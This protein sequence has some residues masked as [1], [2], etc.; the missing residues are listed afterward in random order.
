VVVGLAVALGVGGVAVVDASDHR[1]DNQTDH[2]HPDEVND[3]GDL[4]AVRNW[5]EDRMAQIHLDCAENLSAGERAACRR[6]DDEYP[7]YLD[8]YAS[9]ERDSPGGEDTA[10]TFEKAREDQ[11]EFANETRAHRETY[12]EYQEARAAGDEERSRRL[13][14]ELSDRAQRIEELGGSLN[15]RFTRLEGRTGRDYGD[16][17][18]ATNETTREVRRTTFEIQEVEFTPSRLSAAIENTPASFR[19]PS[20]VEGRLTAENGTALAG[21]TIAVTVDNRTIGT[22]ETDAEGRYN[23]TYRPVT[24]PTGPTTV[25][26]WFQPTGTDPYLGTNASA[27]VAVTSTTADASVE[28]TDDSAAFGDTVPVQVRVTAADRGVAGLPVRVFL[29]GEEIAAGRTGPAGEVLIGS[30]VPATVPADE[31]DL[32][33][34]ASRNGTAI[35]PTTDSTRLTVEPS[36]TKLTVTGLLDGEDLV[37]SGRLTANGRPV[38]DQSVG[39]N[40]DGEVRELDATDRNGRYRVRLPRD[41]GGAGV[42]SVTADY[43]DPSTNLGPASTTRHFTAE[44]LEATDGTDTDTTLPG[45]LRQFF[46]ANAFLR[47]LSDAELLVAAVAGLGLFVVAV[48]GVALGVRRRFEE[49]PTAAPDTGVPPTVVDVSRD[50]AGREATADSTPAAATDETSA[51]LEPPAALDAARGRLGEGRPDEAVKIGYGAVRTQFVTD[52]AGDRDSRTH[53]EF[54]RDAAAELSEERTAALQ[55]LTVAY[56]RAEFAPDGTGPGTAR[57]ALDAVETCLTPSTEG[58]P[59]DVA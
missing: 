14:R 44:D 49:D 59:A 40:V 57:A 4:Q 53:W 6:L 18:R 5:L 20:V 2:Q 11:K 27:E 16:G 46:A 54:Y 17:Q 58:R 56:E 32:T 29:G 30:R 31:R 55:R 12:E 39:V 9:V 50:D 24:T 7:G 26:A 33:L 35:E 41:T 45:K 13:A 48:G 19:R 22:T 43:E 51:T 23:A 1:E 47:S 10:D 25:R 36:E 52:A 38:P 21:R 3:E 28:V 15:A 34:R 42:W 8:R 37:V